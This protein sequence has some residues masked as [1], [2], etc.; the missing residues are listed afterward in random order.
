[1][2]LVMIVARPAALGPHVPRLPVPV[3]TFEPTNGLRTR[4]SAAG[5]AVSM[6]PASARWFTIIFAVTK[7]L[8]TPYLTSSH[9]GSICMYSTDLDILYQSNYFD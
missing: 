6:I 9:R 5:R 8:N 4:K 3:R 1:M 7:K 2:L